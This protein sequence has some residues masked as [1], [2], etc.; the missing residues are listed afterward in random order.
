[1][2]IILAN[3]A[4]LCS[5]DGRLRFSMLNNVAKLVLV[6]PHSNVEEGRLF[7]MVRKNKAAFRPNL[8]LDGTL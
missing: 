7:S 8:K 5:P 3:L 1:M 6:L 2:D 4:S